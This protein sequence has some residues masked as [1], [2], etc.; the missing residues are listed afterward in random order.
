MSDIL[1]FEKPEYVINCIEILS[2]I[3]NSTIAF[4]VRSYLRNH[5]N[6]NHLQKINELGFTV[7]NITHLERT[8]MY[9]V[10]IVRK[11]GKIKI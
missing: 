1:S 4:V 7:E 2:A 9:N 10:Y 8:N 3:E 5:L 11:N 6:T